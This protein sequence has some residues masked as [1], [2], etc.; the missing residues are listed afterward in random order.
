M[1][2]HEKMEIFI[3]SR[4]P[5]KKINMLPMCNNEKWIFKICD[6]QNNDVNF[7]VQHKNEILFFLTR[8]F[9]F[10]VM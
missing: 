6:A 7:F 9:I 10:D 5:M 4:T 3:V 2:K 1:S 8:G